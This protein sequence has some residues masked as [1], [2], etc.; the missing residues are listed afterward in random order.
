MTTKERIVAES[1]TLFASNG[2]KGTTVKSI[3]AAVGIKDSSLYKHFASK[4]EILDEIM[5]AIM[6]HIDKITKQFGLPTDDNIPA[7]A[8]YYSKLDEESLVQLSNGI[9]M[10]Y[11]KDDMILKF[12]RMS[13]MEQFHNKE[14]YSLFREFFMENSINYQAKLF[15]EMVAKGTFKEADP[16]VMAMSFFTPIYFLLSKYSGVTDKDEEIL[17]ILDKQVREFCRIYHR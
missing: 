5:K 16:Q 4:Q 8:E 10:F 11:H 3:A 15:K 9:F 12:W 7:T 1:L 6:L 2:Y 14:I 13:M 17:E